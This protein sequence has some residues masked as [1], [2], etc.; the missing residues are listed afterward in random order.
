M[1]SA[2]ILTLNEEVALPDCLASLAGCPDVVVL[3]SGSTDRTAELARAAGARVFTRAFDSFAGQRNFAH[4]WVLHLDADERMTPELHAECLAAVARPDLDGYRIAPRMIFAGRWVRHCTDYPAYQARLVR[5]QRFVFIQVGHGQREDPTMAM[6]NL[7]QNYLHDLSVYGTE[8]WLAKH[9]RYARDEAQALLGPLGVDLRESAVTYIDIV[10]HKINEQGERS[11]HHLV[12]TLVNL[13]V[14]AVSVFFFFRDGEAY[15]LWFMDLIPM[16]QASKRHLFARV[17]STFTAVVRG[18]LM[19]AML[20]ALL[21]GLGYRLA[22]VRF[23]VLLG[24]V[25]LFAAF[26]PIGGAFLVWGPICLMRAAEGVAPA[27]ILAAWCVAASIFDHVL[28]AYLIGT[29][30]RLPVLVLFLALLGGLYAYGLIGILLGPVLVASALAFI[31]I[32]QEEYG[33]RLPVETPEAPGKGH[34]L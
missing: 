16:E 4:P 15:I 26:I 23:P 3:D 9:R 13:G 25:S 8:S 6:E 20:Q 10:S 1:Y 17:R 18:V 12:L 34:V 19:S 33:I 29:K 28:K 30:A 24:V 14:L 22:G 7:R 2:V 21:L 11:A 27:L 31:G 5:A 32:Y